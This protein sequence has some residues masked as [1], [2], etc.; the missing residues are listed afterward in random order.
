MPNGISEV[1]RR[2]IV[3]FLSTSSIAWAGRLNEDAF[4]ARIYDLASM[5]S[6]DYRRSNAAGDVFQH[7][8]N[9]QDW[10]DDWVFSDARFNPPCAGR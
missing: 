1:T 5:P 9:W 8:I 6:T 2:A 10:P 3:D 7:R 4:L